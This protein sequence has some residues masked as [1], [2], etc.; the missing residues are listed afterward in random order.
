M[1]KIKWPIIIVSTY[2][3]VYQFSYYIG[4]PIGIVVLL[5]VVSPLAV[6]WMVYKILKDG[7]PSKRSFH[8]YF[9]EDSNYK[10]DND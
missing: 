4:L 6:I 3:L 9:Y 8:E 1:Q 2:M 10:R 7:T 5:F